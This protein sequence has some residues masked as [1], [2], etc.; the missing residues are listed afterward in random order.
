MVWAWPGD[1]AKL[2]YSSTATEATRL[3]LEFVFFQLIARASY[4]DIVANM[5]TIACREA[6]S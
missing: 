4:G 2:G 1:E 3:R 6:C 5:R